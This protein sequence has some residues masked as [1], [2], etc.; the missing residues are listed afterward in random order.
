MTDTFVKGFDFILTG[1]GWASELEKCG[2]AA[3]ITAGVPT[4]SFLD[5]WCNYLPRFRHG[6]AFIF[7]DEIWVGD[8]DAYRLARSSFTGQT[9]RLVPNPYFLDVEKEFLQMSA[10][11]EHR[12]EFRIL[13][14]CEAIS[15]SGRSLRRPRW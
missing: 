11:H 6:D 13:Y 1:T 12:R 3:G 15:E 2:V 4:A 14:L 7:P 5:H 10:A 8:D 9:I